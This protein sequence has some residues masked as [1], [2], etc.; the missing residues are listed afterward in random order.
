MV[1]P[2]DRFEHW[3]GPKRPEDIAAIWEQLR[4]AYLRL[5]RVGY[6]PWASTNGFIQVTR[7]VHRDG[8]FRC[9][10]TQ[11]HHRAAIVSRLGY[12]KIWVLLHRT[13]RQGYPR[14]MPDTVRL[15]EAASW[16][17][18]RNDRFSAEDAVAFFEAYFRFN[19]TERMP[20]PCSIETMPR[21]EAPVCR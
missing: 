3:C 21:V 14:N 9:L 11:G 6:R 17:N 2:A 15:T 12:Q 10:V 4:E 20:K 5:K 19:G 13:G 8:T 1:N 18:V 7:L 16:P